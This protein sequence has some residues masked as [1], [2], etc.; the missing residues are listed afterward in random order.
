MFAVTGN[1]NGVIGF[2]MGKGTTA[3]GALKLAKMH[4]SQ[5]L[6]Y[7]ERCEGRTLFHNLYEEYYYTRV[8]AEKVPAG[9]GLVGHR[10]IKLL[11]QLIGIKDVY[12]KVEGS[13][14]S[15]N[16]AKG[17]ICGLLN[18]RDYSEI[19]KKKNKYVVEFRPDMKQFPLV[20]AEPPAQ[21]TT[22]QLIELDGD[23]AS[24]VDEL[25]E[26]RDVI[27]RR[28][29]DLFLFKDRC[30]LEKKRKLPFY[31]HYPSYQKYLKRVAEVLLCFKST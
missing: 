5:R 6:L 28:N 9:Y 25:S 8:Y 10:V 7:I 19:A 14:N 18:Q 1:G 23:T 27:M 31:Y 2:G 17:F 13:R 20:L 22:E 11:C 4:A 30:R 16:V 29:I 3:S 21:L 15:L 12:A 24:A 26:S